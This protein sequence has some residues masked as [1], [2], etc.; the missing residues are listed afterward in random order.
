MAIIPKGQEPA[1]VKKRIDTL[2]PKLDGAYPD[3]VIVGLR[4]DHKKWD[5]TAREI[6]R[7]LGY[8]N[9]NDFLIAYGYK[10]EKAET[11]RPK[12]DPLAVIEE[13][14]KCYPNGSAFEKYSDLIEANPDLA[15]QIK[16]LSNRANELFGMTLGKYLMSIGL[17][18]TC[19]TQAEIK[20]INKE[21]I[22]IS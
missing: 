13:L 9:K 20:A 4:R 2:F 22:L 1:N 15:G 6:S 19:V 3:K 7:Q 18:T 14:K 11:G 5:E 17:L 21:Y 12:G 10:I 16:T 8:A